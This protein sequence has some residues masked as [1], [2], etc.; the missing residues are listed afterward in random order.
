MIW[1]ARVIK[2]FLSVAEACQ[3]LG[4]NDNNIRAACN[5]GQKTCGG[6]IWGY[7]GDAVPTAFSHGK[8]RRVS[9]FNITGEIIATYESIA[10]AVRKTGYTTGAS[11]ISRCAQGNKD[12]Y[13]G[14]FGAIREI[15]H[16]HEEL[17]NGN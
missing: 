3:A 2:V 17:T 16:D 13:M 7:E 11:Y 6:Y 10:D 5:G 12:S 14:I 4:Q 9:Q 15:P 8:K 1:R